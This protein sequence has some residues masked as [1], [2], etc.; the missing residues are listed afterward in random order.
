MD[1]FIERLEASRRGVVQRGTYFTP[2][3]DFWDEMI[4]INCTPQGQ[5][6]RIRYSGTWGSLMEIW[7]LVGAYLSDAMSYEQKRT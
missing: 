1:D 7:Q 6:L 4:D 5:D 2:K 3:R